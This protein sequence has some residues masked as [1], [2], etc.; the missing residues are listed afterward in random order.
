MIS[1]EAENISAG[2][3]NPKDKNRMQVLHEVSFTV[4]EGRNVCILG[5]N[6]S[7]KTTLLKVIAGMLPYTGSV[8]I[9][10]QDIQK[11]KRREIAEQVAMMLQFSDI[12]FSYT[13]RETVMLGR[14][15]HIDNFFGNP[16]RQDREIA[17]QAME[18]TG[19]SDLAERQIGALSGGQRQRVFLA[20]TFAQHTP[21]ILLDEPTNH[22]DLKYQE[23]LMEYLQRWSEQETVLADGS[24]HRNTVIGVFHDINLAFGIAQDVIF[25]KDGRIVAQGEKN[26]TVT[27][28]MLQTVY[29]IDVVNYM[30]RQLNHWK[31]L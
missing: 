17:E 4:P 31:E 11:L 7:G 9:S 20:R 16:G 19:V 24:H 8:R 28:E 21:V 23:E 27:A 1:L 15:L 13:V 26:Q 10:G 12:Y 29:D 18:A 14:Y 25:L 30:K 6:G 5:A 22:L 2:Y 3:G